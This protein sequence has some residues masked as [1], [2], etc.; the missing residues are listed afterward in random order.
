MQGRSSMPFWKANSASHLPNS[1]ISSPSHSLY[2]IPSTRTPPCSTLTVPLLYL[3]VFLI[4]VSCPLLTSCPLMPNPWNQG[5]GL[6]SE[7]SCKTALHN[8]SWQNPDESSLLFLSTPVKNL[9]SVT[10]L[11]A[12]VNGHFQ[13]VSSTTPGPFWGSLVPI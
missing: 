4:S 13:H 7:W 5:K 11:N 6:G 8:R 9:T 1:P 12:F 2:S 10:H 3:T